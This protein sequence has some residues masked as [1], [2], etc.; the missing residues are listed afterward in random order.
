MVVNVTSP[1]GFEPDGK[2]LVT[3]AKLRLLHAGVRNLVRR[4]IP[5]YEARYGLPVNH[6]DML[7]TIM[8]FSLLVIR[9]LEKLQVGLSEQEAEDYYYLWRVYALAMG[10]HPR[11]SP[12]STEYLPA[13]LAEADEFYQSYARRHYRPA[14]EN[15]EGVEL[16]RA[17]LLMLE[18]MVADTPLRLLGIR[19]VPRV[20]MQ[21]LLGADGLVHRGIQPVRYHALTTWTLLTLLKLGTR[22]AA[23]GDRGGF[24][25]F[26]ERLSQ[27]FF[28]GLIN[29]TLQGEVTFLIPERI[30]DLRA[31]ADK[32]VRPHG[33]RRRAERR[34]LPSR[35]VHSNRRH[36]KADRRLAFRQSF[37]GYG[38]SD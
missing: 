10:I 34:A 38:A 36:T 16:T 17:S 32:A 33:E 31:L 20:Y 19:L 2:A 22:I 37:W 4:R 3:A 13:N 5:D 14:A 25:H 26:H 35:M 9:G 30:A 23:R 15:P 21:Q 11:G 6:E 1:G 29:R 7:A 27:E 8:G 12:V 24:R 28:Q 18:H